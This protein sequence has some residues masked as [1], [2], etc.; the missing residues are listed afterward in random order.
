M[1]GGK[2]HESARSLNT[3]SSTSLNNFPSSCVR[4]KSCWFTQASKL[5]AGPDLSVTVFPETR[6]LH[7]NSGKGNESAGYGGNLGRSS[8]LLN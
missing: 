2:S 4:E 5:A 6:Y 3:N 8:S 7:I 1:L